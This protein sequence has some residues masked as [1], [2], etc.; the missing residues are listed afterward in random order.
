MSMIVSFVLYLLLRPLFEDLLER[1]LLTI[2]EIKPSGFVLILLVTLLPGFIAG[3]YP[4][5]R[6]SGFKIVHAVKGKLPF[7]FL[8]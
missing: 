3:I 5:F 6:L 4:A 2:Q 1:P 7:L 8:L